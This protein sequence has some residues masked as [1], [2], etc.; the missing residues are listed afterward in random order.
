MKSILKF[1]TVRI[2]V[3]ALFVLLAAQCGNK[4][5]KKAEPVKIDPAFTGYISGYTA[6]EVSKRATIQIE[7]R[8]PFT[9]VELEQPVKENYFKF[10]PGIKGDAYWV[11]Q[12]TLE[13]RPEKPLPSGDNYT[14]KFY[15]G[16]LMDVPENLSVFEFRFNIRDQFVNVSQRGLKNYTVKDLKRQFLTGSVY[17]SDWAEDEQVEA[18]FTPKQDGRLL[19]V[20]WEHNSESNEHSFTVDSIF[21]TEKNSQVLLSWDGKNIGSRDKGELYVEVPALGD[22]KVLST[23]VT[24][25]PNQSVAIYFSDPLDETQDLEGLIYL[26]DNV[27]FRLEVEKNVV[28]LYTKKREIIST[29]IIVEK[30]I[31]NSMGYQLS[32]K[33]MHP[34]TFE[35][36][37][38]SVQ[39]IGTGVILPSANGLIFPFRAVNL[40]AVKVKIVKIFEP[41]IHQFLQI[42]QLPGSREL[43]R[44]GRIVYKGIVP[45]TSDKAIDLGSWN[46]FSLDLSTLIAPEPGAIYRVTVGFGAAQSLYP[47]QAKITDGASE[48]FLFDDPEVSS[49]D[50]P[51]YY[52]DYEYYYEEEYEYDER[53]DYRERDN[54]CHIS[55]Y[56]HNRHEFSRNIL[57]SDLGII[58][59]GGSDKKLKVAV[60]D[61]R[62]TDPLA[63]VQ[64]DVYNYQDQIVGSQVT[65]KD[66]MADIEMSSK[67]FLL[68]AKQG[69]QRGYMRLDDG[70]AL[71]VSMFDVA[72]D[73][74]RKGLKGLI[75]GERGVWRPGDSLFIN[76]IL[77]DEN[78]VMPKG[79][80][81]VFELYTPENQQ[82][83]RRVNTNSVNGFYAFHVVT[84]PD[85]PTGN[86]LAKVN[87][88]GVVFTKTIRIETVKPNRL[89]INIDFTNDI[90]KYQNDN[91]ADISVKWLHGA[92]AR[93]LTTDVVVTMEQ[94]KTSFDNYQDYIF[95]DPVKKYKSEEYTLFDGQVDE[96]GNAHFN[97]RFQVG[98]SA[99]GMLKAN[100]KVRAFEKSGDFSVDRFSVPYSSYASYVGSKV[101]QGEGWHGALY[102]DEPNMIPIVTVDESGNPIDRRQVK[103]EVYEIKWRWWWESYDDDDLADF[104]SRSSTHNILTTFVDTKGGKAMF[105]LKLKNQYWGRLL[106]RV[107]DPVSGHTS[108]QFFYSS[109]R[110]WWSRP[111]SGNP[112]GAE[113]LI[114][115]TDKEKYKVGEEVQIDLPA[116]ESGR[117]LV[118][119]ESGTK[120]IDCFWVKPDAYNHT[121]SFKATSEMTPNVYVHI[122]YIQPHGYKGNDLPIRMYGIQYIAVEDP[123]THLQPV[124][125]M[126]DVLVPEEEVTITV[127]EKDNRP[128]TYTIAVVDE[129]L[130][131]LTRF[132]TPDAWRAFYVREALGV[133]TWDMYQYVMGAFTGEM[134]GLLALGGDEEI[135]SE[136]G[137]K[138]NRFKPV[139]KFFGP[140]ELKSGKASHT[141]T[142]PNYVGSVK[143]MVVAGQDGSYGKTD[144]VTPVK[145]PLMVL[146]T[147]PRV[148]APAEGVVLPVTVFAMD[149]NIK[150]VQVKLE[151][152]D[153]LSIEGEGAQKLL[154]EHTGDQM[155]YFNL[156]VN[157]KIGIA[158]AHIEVSSGKEKATYDIELDVR[159]PNPPITVSQL[160]KVDPGTEMDI[161][162][163][164][165]GIEGTNTGAIE[166]T[167]MPPL[168]LENRLK[169]L[170]RYPHGCVEQTTSSVF[171][172]LYLDRLVELTPAEKSNIESNITN[173]IS[174]LRHFQ[175]SDGGFSYWS[176]GN[177]ANDW[178]SS[179]AGHFLFE[180]KQ[181]GYH[182]SDA[183]IANW[184]NYQR[185]EANRY[186]EEKYR[187]TNYYHSTHLIQAYR[188]YTL[189]LV[190][191]PSIGAM[192]R[193]R[194]VNNLGLAAKWRLA[195]AYALAGRKDVAVEM[196]RN[197]DL[198]VKSYREMSYSYGSSTRDNAMILETLLALGNHEQAFKAV[199]DISDQLCNNTWMSTQTT[200][201]CLLAIGKYAA[202][203]GTSNQMKFTYRF[204]NQKEVSEHTSMPIY[205]TD[206]DYSKGLSGKVKV[207]NNGEATLFAQVQLSGTPQENTQ[208][209]FSNDL[210]MT[211]RFMDMSR[212]PMDI[213]KLQQGTDFMAEVIVRHPGIRVPYR[214]LALTQI[215]PSGW[216]IRNIRMDNAQSVHVA[217]EPTYQDIRDDRVYTYFDLNKS[218]VHTY[219]ILLNAAYEGK[220]YQPGTYCE[221]MYDNEISAFRP[222]QWVEVVRN[223]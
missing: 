81:V 94:G 54:P 63:G 187:G 145:K 127:S 70:S 199:K 74:V 67:P 209:A 62:S 93:N 98:A 176:G 100:F 29:E 169:Y 77:E 36:M 133:K 35:S 131:D 8:Q 34:V 148:L 142:M 160:Y 5:A 21:R 194:E 90:L 124:L 170:I 123:Q 85:A 174:R 13:F 116:N 118:S 97:A 75:Y 147:L 208:E 152:N 6:G 88:G 201:Y 115:K 223:E 114:F 220:F 112:G 69:K 111:G 125:S 122:S 129:G 82:Y 24:Q 40:S 190:G 56:M 110:G 193:L 211:V 158:R 192:N 3:F 151:V 42:N 7:F 47:C 27:P 128:M 218:A 164:A 191:K 55:Y 222:G 172:Q 28:T 38:P 144:K 18:L 31:R 119:I 135:L 163:S 109:Y 33:Y 104:I 95:D 153:K 143:T 210:E 165:V 197:I 72:G 183:V 58:A 189:A 45:L 168:N 212:T 9:T 132:R 216:E 83:L 121:F 51:S 1:S 171:P 48:G 73:P 195:L 102:T 203:T 120:V 66:G 65:D 78:K 155:A 41:N 16:K 32:E 86:W 25:Q 205:T 53:Y 20:T 61:L 99:P 22:F 202:S 84:Q 60:T 59:K 182:V 184:I 138:A 103:V 44:V 106:L 137:K 2:I 87:I 126:P 166:F 17:L 141:F 188:L 162:Y 173:G 96:N 167:S 156:K 92:A 117:A 10:S 80:P 200:A 43:K 64:I 50:N 185:R 52:Y 37:K 26:K 4:Q 217:D 206:I 113:M 39:D 215:F 196:V 139:V 150:N 134:A 68:V 11:N 91:P 219:R 101:L 157:Q 181:K 146:G 161:D 105:E 15:L 136:G 49:Y 214:E 46:T 140:F 221:A 179:Y 177:E 178:G 198:R 149:E 154:F 89:K 108:G 23:R 30:G 71:S 175:L 14:G 130:L 204:P 76:F 107:T 207:K 186:D 57:A 79:H 159:I 19:P 180:A 12:Y 213:S